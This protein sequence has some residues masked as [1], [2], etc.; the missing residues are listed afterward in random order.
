LGLLVLG[1]LGVVGCTDPATEITDVAA[2]LRANWPA[3]DEPTTYWFQYGKTTTYGA[4]TPHRSIGASSAAQ[5]VSERLK[6]L[7]PDTTYHYRA[8]YSDQGGS[9][10]VQDRSFR[11]GSPGLLPGFQETT[12]VTGLEAPTAVRFAPDG[13]MF[14]A[15]KPGL[16]KVF[17]GVGDTTPTTFANLRTKVNH[18]W[19]RG[20]LGL[21][22]DPDFPA[23][24]FV[25]VL[26]T[27]DAPIGG[28]APTFNDTCP[29]PPG[30]NPNGCV[31]SARL[32]R[33]QAE[34]DHMIGQEQ[35]LIEDWCQ[36]GPTHTI[37]DLRFGPDGALYVSAGDA[38]TPDTSDYG[39]FGI[40]RNPCGDP[41]VG[42]GGTQSPPTAE[43]GAL[44]SQ[45]LR[46]T[47]DPTGLD[48]TILRL[49]PDTG[50]ALPTN[51]LAGS[52]DQ[53]ARR[54]I[55]YGLRNPYRFAIRP[56][57]REL[58]LGDVGWNTTEEINRIPDY[59]DTT[60]ENFGWPCFEGLVRQS[61]YDAANLN[62]C[63]SL[64]S[65]GG[66][67][68]P[69]FSYAHTAKVDAE[70]TCPTGGSAVTGLAF[71]PPG[72]PLPAEFDDALFFADYARGCIWAMER[73]AGGLPSPTKI[74][75]FRSGATVPVDLQFG[76]GG[77]VFY[78]DVWNGKIKRIRYT[79]G[80]QAP[81][82]VALATP[83]SGD[84]PL[85]VQFDARGSSDPE[86]Q[87]LSYAWD[88]DGDG[89]YDDSSTALQRWTYGTAGSYPVGL[90]VTDPSGATSTD[91][92]AITA[93]NTPPVATISAP[94]PGLRW[95]VGQA[96]SFAGSATD[97]KDGTLPASALDWSLVLEHCPSNCHEHAV[98]TFSDMSSGSFPAPD[99]EYP[100]HLELR[101]TATDSGGLTDT[102]AVSLDPRTVSVSLRSTPTGLTLALN[103]AARATPFAAT[104]IEGSANTL[105]APTPQTLSGA[106]YD[107]GSWSDG[108]LGT[109]GI[110]AA[111]SG[112]YTATYAR[113]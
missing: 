75:W 52:S 31:T 56:G 43:G 103:G 10:C 107:F 95:R 62:L 65:G 7:T 33:L 69:Y 15:E 70:E 106:T 20:L 37:G 34:G 27:H 77:D 94:S 41:P 3:H 96:I 32:S 87:D 44:R 92:V 86:G 26:Y 61:G 98:G 35:V 76:P 80:N 82:A 73:G 6:G 13:R 104:V 64:Y 79:E 46:T 4:E 2:T 45:D 89:A 48:G 5:D 17:D 49:N 9:S 55:A 68:A 78:A 57:T 91:T 47:S 53:N 63:E 8:C 16:I 19:D 24:P 50:E 108:G 58:W 36:Q 67:K 100:S 81:R 113:R 14:V 66:A 12:I 97:S 60:V 84:T 74:R 39:Q 102:Q 71:N 110:T 54:I 1:A 21:A 30:G 111:A 105:S 11:T 85:A 25:Y 22:L 18:Y 40:P 93:G 99:H 51:P 42:V 29:D 112:T 59:L 28:M 72:S 109:H 88:T 101:L 90:K 38:A 83:T 23:K